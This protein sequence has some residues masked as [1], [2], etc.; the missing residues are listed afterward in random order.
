M[1][2]GPYGQPCRVP[3]CQLLFVDAQPDEL[4][5]DLVVLEAGELGNRSVARGTPFE[6]RFRTSGPTDQKVAV[7]SI[8]DLLTTW[9]AAGA[10]IEVTGRRGPAGKGLLLSLGRHCIALVTASGALAPGLAQ[11]FRSGVVWGQRQHSTAVG[12]DLFW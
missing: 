7:K 3:T 6:V 1:T 8:T 5:M 9:S 4:T 12:G 2:P 10:V 11:L